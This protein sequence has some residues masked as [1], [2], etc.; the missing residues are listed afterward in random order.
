MTMY[1]PADAQNLAK[2]AF[3]DVEGVLKGFPLGGKAL[4]A[5]RHTGL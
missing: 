4:G 2:C 1:I 3:V 5:V